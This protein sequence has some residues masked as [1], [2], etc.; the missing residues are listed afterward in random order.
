MY[1]N[2]YKKS[3]YL[4]LNI[5][6]FIVNVNAEG[7]NTNKEHIF[8][9]FLSQ[10]IWEKVK[11]NKENTVKPL[12]WEIYKNQNTIDF[13]NN[14]K[15]NIFDINNKNKLFSKSSTFLLNR[16]EKIFDYGFNINNSNF[17][18][19]KIGLSKSFNIDFSSELISSKK[20]PNKQNKIKDTFLG[21]DSKHVRVGG[22]L[23]IFS[24]SRG[25]LIST[26]LRLSYGERIGEFSQ[27]YIFKEIIN[28]YSINDWLTFNF[29]P[30]FSNTILGNIYSIRSGFNW[31]LNSKLEIIPEGNIN[32]YQAENNY[33]LTARSY[34]TKNMI[35][36]T[37]ISNTF[38]FRDMAKQFKSESTN[39]GIKVRLRF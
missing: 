24:Q 28:K 16:G 23:Q 17:Y 7:R 39:Y 3:I 10:V 32:L 12:R 11:E 2:F 20:N 37:F 1:N 13:K 8:K 34:L 19:L 38:G 36:D 4:L 14:L 26:N 22:T 25:D 35:I 29:S 30:Q 21:Q 27:G 18:I 6:I 33:S 5:S 31:R 15:K 9:Q